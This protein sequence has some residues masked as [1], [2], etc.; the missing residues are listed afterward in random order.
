MAPYNPQLVE[1]VMSALSKGWSVSV[2]P[3]GDLRYDVPGSRVKECHPLPKS[4]LF[5]V[6][7]FDILGGLEEADIDSDD[8]VFKMVNSIVKERPSRETKV[9]KGSINICIN[10]Q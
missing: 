5:E 4:S 8:E 9:E 7:G 3:D 1:L 2:T 10:L 6:D